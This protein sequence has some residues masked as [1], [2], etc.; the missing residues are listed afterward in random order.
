MA[1]ARGNRFALHA[2]VCPAAVGT[3]RGLAS[4]HW[5]AKR[6]RLAAIHQ[7]V[8]FRSCNGSLA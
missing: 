4:P 5:S 6:R 2:E 8:E 1:F 3:C 7:A